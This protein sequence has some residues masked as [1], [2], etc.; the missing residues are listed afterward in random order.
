MLHLFD[1]EGGLIDSPQ[2]FTYSHSRTHDGGLDWHGWHS[3]TGIRS[4]TYSAD[5][6]AIDGLQANVSPY[7]SI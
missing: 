6:V 1:T 5:Y 2:V 3:P 4:L 7:V